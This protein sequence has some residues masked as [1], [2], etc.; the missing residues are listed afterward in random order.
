MPE[1]LEQENPDHKLEIRPENPDLLC[2]WGRIS[3]FL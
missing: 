3:T 1:K 2:H